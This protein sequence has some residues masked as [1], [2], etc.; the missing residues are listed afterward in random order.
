M[1]L[2]DERRWFSKAR[3]VPICLLVLDIAD[4]QIENILTFLTIVAA[5][6]RLVTLQCEV[7]IGMFRLL[8]MRGA[9][10]LILRLIQTA[11]PVLRSKTTIFEVSTRSQ[12]RRIHC[13]LSSVKIRLSLL[14]IL[15]ANLGHHADGNLL[16]D[17]F[18]PCSGVS[19]VMERCVE[20]LKAFGAFARELTPKFKRRLDCSDAHAHAGTRLW[21]CMMHNGSKGF[22]IAL[23]DEVRDVSSGL[24]LFGQV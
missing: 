14:D 18:N 5:R 13:Q 11:H 24:Y 6:P 1:A 19:C 12:R 9:G 8:R 21:R 20:S 17:D 10:T 22:K 7:R 23:V 16:Q 15:N 4:E 3:T 2:V